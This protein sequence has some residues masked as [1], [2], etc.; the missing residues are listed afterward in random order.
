MPPP[1]THTQKRLGKWCKFLHC[2]SFLI[3]NLNTQL[4]IIKIKLKTMVVVI[5]IIR[6]NITISYIMLLW[7]SSR[8][9][10]TED[11]IRWRIKRCAVCRLH[12]VV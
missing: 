11:Y 4:N 2:G 8:I 12:R 1:P 5:L 10:E 3:P 6:L 9:L 7:V